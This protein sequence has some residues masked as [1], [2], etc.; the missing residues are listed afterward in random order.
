MPA[1]SVIVV[2]D[3]SL[4]LADDPAGLLTGDSYE[5]QVT[6][7]AIG[8]TPN[9]QTVPATWCAPETQVPAATGYELTVEWLQDWRDPA[10]G[11]SGY[12]YTNDTLEKAF[13]LKLDKDDTTPVAT[14]LVRI[15]AGG[16]GGAA[17]VPL[18]ATAV[19]PI[20]GKPTIT[21]PA[22]A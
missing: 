20:Q 12:A 15:V 17:G 18:A 11:L 5:C 9:L 6:T 19:W 13:E 3:G 21:M 22:A 2:T 7:C 14:G 4:T 8:A 10:G 1:A 16:Y